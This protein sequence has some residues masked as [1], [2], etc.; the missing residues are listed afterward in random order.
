[1]RIAVSNDYLP[2]SA[3]N[4]TKKHSL[5]IAAIALFSALAISP[6]AHALTYNATF[7]S[8]VSIVSG[9]VN[10]VAV[11]NP[12]QVTLALDNGGSSLLNQ[13]WTASD[14]VSVTFDFNNGAHRTVFN[15]NGGN[16][17][18]SSTGSFV[19]NGS[20]V[21]TSVL[22]NWFDFSSVNVISTNSSQTPD[23]WY[24]NGFNSVYGVSGNYVDINN[25]SNMT[26]ASSWSI[27]PVPVPFA[28]SPLPG[29]VIGGMVSRFKR[30]KQSQDTA[31]LS[32]Q[33]KA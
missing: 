14:L 3:K 9:S 12:L 2:G 16:G 19:T 18:D 15:P 11:G 33:V 31:D 22:S 13:T 5:E 26:T 10:N 30:R 27:A 29:L 25:V 23:E 8:T 21:L 6:S 17:L 32:L 24:L 28:F 1:M 20:G 7:N 4:M